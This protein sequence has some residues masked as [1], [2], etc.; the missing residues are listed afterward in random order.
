MSLHICSFGRFEFSDFDTFT[1]WQRTESEND[2]PMLYIFITLL[3][4][5]LEKSLTE[6]VYRHVKIALFK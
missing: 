3:G 2:P 4:K 5:A 6:N 1:S